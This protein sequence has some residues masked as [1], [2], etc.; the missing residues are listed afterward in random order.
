MIYDF[1][2]IGGLT[3]DVVFFT[4]DGVLISNKKNLLQQ[5]LLAFEYGAKINIKEIG[6]YFGGG[7][8]NS[9]VNLSNLGFRVACLAKNGSDD[10][11]KRILD[12]LKK[13]KINCEN[14]EIDKKND[15]GF[16]FIVNNKKDRII[17]TYRGAN[18]YLEIKPSHQKIIKNS[19]WVYLSSLPDNF[20]NS[21]KNIYNF[22]NKIAWN[23]GLNQLS[24][25]VNPISS[26][27]KN[28]DIF[29]LNKDEGLE[30]IKKTTKFNSIK[31]SF[32]NNSK[33]LIKILKQFG[34]N[35]I[36]LTEGAKGAYFYDGNNFYHQKI[37]KGQK[38]IDSTGVG[39]AFN[40]TVASLL[41]KYNGD[42]KKAMFCG[43]K[44]VSSVIA[45]CGAQNGL[46][47]LEKLIKK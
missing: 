8:S 1:I 32:L 40:S 36:I 3:E 44:N 34:P 18:E 21:L 11:G 17:F 14:I 30:L 29:M 27:L 33:N 41:D 35:K 5:K 10:R 19:N 2:T 6:Y 4:E 20:I 42:F 16:S 9:A 23:P 7:A 39:D 24:K 22:K 37:I 25:G 28:T 31:N 15:S 47:S 43:V 13:N 26:F 45:Y 46:L 12:N 38:R